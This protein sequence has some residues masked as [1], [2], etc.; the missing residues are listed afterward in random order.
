MALRAFDATVLAQRPLGLGV[1]AQQRTVEAQYHDEF[2]RACSEVLGRAYLRSEWSDQSIGSSG[3]V[4]FFIPD[5]GWAIELLR[6]SDNIEEHIARFQPNG[7][8]Y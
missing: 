2:Y 1:A 6:D 8:Y 3:R 4:D 7:R 5:V